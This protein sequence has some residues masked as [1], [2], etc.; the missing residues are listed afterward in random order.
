MKCIKILKSN[1]LLL[2]LLAYLLVFKTSIAHASAGSAGQLE[3]SRICGSAL[4][5]LQGIEGLPIETE[6][7]LRDQGYSDRYIAGFDHVRENLLLAE[8]LRRNKIKPF[9]SHVK[10]FADLIVPHIEFIEEGIKLQKAADKQKRLNLLAALKSEAQRRQSSEQVT[11]SYWAHLNL[12]LSILATP[13]EHI[14][15]PEDSHDINIESLIA[16]KT[17][18]DMYRFIKD[19]NSIQM[20]RIHLSET[21]EVFNAFPKKIMLPT[22]HPLGITSL[23][24]THGTGVHLIGLNNKF[25][26]A[27]DQ[28][29][30]PY[31]FFI[32]DIQHAL[33]QVPLSNIDLLLA[34]YVLRQIANFPKPQREALEYIFFDETHEYGLTLALY[35]SAIPSKYRRRT[36]ESLDIDLDIDKASIEEAENNLER[37]M[38]RNPYVSIQFR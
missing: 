26:P 16:N 37:I 7:Q 22:I 19:N 18:E 34:R 30:S 33:Q 38:R 6:Q 2:V 21:L 28:D 20:F 5:R 3:D 4:I 11:Y 31:R 9:T 36:T 17:I 13:E 14:I 35:F 29:M 15:L 10:E 12:I 32:H 25:V 1:H 27:D 8:R 24:N 23:N